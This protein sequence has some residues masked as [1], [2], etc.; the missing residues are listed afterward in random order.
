MKQADTDFPRL[1]VRYVL[2]VNRTAGV[3]AVEETISLAA[4]H[5][6][7]SDF[8]VGIELSG[9]PRAGVFSDFEPL[10]EQART[11]HKLK[12]SLHCAET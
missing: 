4:K 5:K 2:S 11:E 8:V 12:I 1:V 7:S 3:D 6:E 10:F 9:D